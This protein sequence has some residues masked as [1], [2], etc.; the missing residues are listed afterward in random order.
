MHTR[1]QYRTRLVHGLCCLALLLA[2]IAIPL[3]QPLTVQAAPKNV[4]LVVNNA[5]DNNLATCTA[6]S[7]GND[8]T[9]R[10][11]IN[12][13][14][15][16]TLT[17][18]TITFA[19]QVT[20]TALLNPLPAIVVTGTTILGN[21]GVPRLDAFFMANGNVF[22]VSAPISQISG[23]SIVN[24]HRL[25][26]A[27]LPTFGWKAETTFGSTITTWARCRLA[28]PSRTARPIRT[29]AAWSRATRAMACS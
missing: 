3:S 8:C 16:G 9:L 21:S 19:P 4:S 24:G 7:S 23:L 12:K 15:A 14:N 20:L 22:S 27:S 2:A 29:G 17:F 25:P 10:G 28:Q 5:S 11:A 13:I 6:G 1:S 18:A 26:M